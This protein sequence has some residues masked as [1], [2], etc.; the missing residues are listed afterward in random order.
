MICRHTSWKNLNGSY[1]EC[2]KCG[3]WKGNRTDPHNYKRE[4]Y[5]KNNTIVD[6]IP[7]RQW[8]WGVHKAIWDGMGIDFREMEKALEFGCGIGLLLW[9]IY[10]KYNIKCLGVESS[11][12]AYDWQ[13]ETHGF[14]S[15]YRIIN[16]N[17]EETSDPIL[18]NVLESEDKLR[19]FDMIYSCHVM[20]HLKNPMATV[21]RCF[22]L[23][24]PEGV[25]Y[26]TVPDKEHQKSLHVHAWT[27]DEKCLRLWF[28]HAGFK[29]IQIVKTKP[30]NPPPTDGDYP[31]HYL[32]V[33]GR[34]ND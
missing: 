15:D 21:E 2:K 10:R 6:G 1:K 29:D 22:E 4:Y 18:M 33:S 9:S 24:N 23:L 5:H 7:Q 16:D 14:N 31:G 13:K 30:H 27:Y 17:F 26:I 12:W 34:K 32:H 28:S 11:F 25:F 3:V 19:C 20:E 8:Y